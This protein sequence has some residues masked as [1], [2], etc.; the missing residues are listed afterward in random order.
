MMHKIP[1]MFRLLLWLKEV[2]V[3]NT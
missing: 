1:D 3:S 2:N